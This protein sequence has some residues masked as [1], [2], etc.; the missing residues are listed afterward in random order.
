MCV[1]IPGELDMSSL[2][3][4]KL[5]LYNFNGVFAVTESTEAV[6]AESGHVEGTAE[7]K[8]WPSPNMKL[9]NI[10]NCFPILFPLYLFFSVVLNWKK[11]MRSRSD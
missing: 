3:Y 11:C 2:H 6:G 1:N 4:N 5:L 7:G 8:L 9:N 10:K